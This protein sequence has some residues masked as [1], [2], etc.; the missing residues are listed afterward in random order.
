VDELDVILR[1][2]ADQKTDFSEPVPVIDAAAHSAVVLLNAPPV[3]ERIS[4]EVF[5]A[6][7]VAPAEH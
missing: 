7:S 2:P 3:D 6:V 4:P 5:P 1:M